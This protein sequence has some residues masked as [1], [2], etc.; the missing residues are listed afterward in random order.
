MQLNEL[1]LYTDGSCKGNPGN[2]GWAVIILEKGNPKPIEKLK[3][4]DSATTNNRME[5]IAV[6]E[7]LRFIHEN[8]LQNRKLSLFSDSNLIIKTLTE[9][10]KR[11]A[12]LDLW[13]ELDALNEEIEVEYVWVKG[14]SDNKW[15]NEAD[16][17]AQM[18][19]DIAGK[20]HVKSKEYGNQKKMF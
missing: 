12:N 4:G 8:H 5:M 2:G 17:I 11:K 1:E 16:K 18:Q 9:G 7:G 14:H 3:G 13:E 10:W 15:N 20:N 19:A 6:I